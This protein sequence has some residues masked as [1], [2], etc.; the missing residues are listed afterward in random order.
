MKKTTVT[1]S[2]IINSQ[3]SA[4]LMGFKLTGHSNQHRSFSTKYL[5]FMDSLRATCIFVT[6]QLT[7]NVLWGCISHTVSETAK[8]RVN[9]LPTIVFPDFETAIH[10]AVTTVWPGLEVKVRRFHLGQSWWRKIQSCGL[11]KQYGKRDPEVI[12]FL[13]KIFGLYFYHRWKS[14]PALRWNSYP[15]F[16]NKRVELFC[17]YLLKKLYWRKLHF[18]SVCLVRM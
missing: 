18:S 9:V 5:Q 1:F 6:G 14:A 17:D 11:S 2:C 3:F 13:K 4:P 7:S 15:I 10:N 16:R 12:Q 8:L